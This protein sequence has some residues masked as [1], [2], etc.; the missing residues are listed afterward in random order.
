MDRKAALAS[1]FNRR[2]D[3]ALGRASMASKPKKTVTDDSISKGRREIVIEPSC[4]VNPAFT[5]EDN[6]LRVP[7]FRS[8][9]LREDV[10]KGLEDLKFTKPTVTQ[11]VAIPPILYRE[12]VLCAAQ[13]GTGKTLA[14]LLPIVHHLREEQDR[15]VMS[16]LKRPRALIVLPNR[17]LA[18]QVLKVAKSLCHTARFRSA[19]LTGGKKLRILKSGLESPVDLLVGTPGTLLE[20]RERGRLFFSDVSYLVIDEADSMFDKTFK[21]ETME[22][23]EAINIRQDKPPPRSSLPVD[24]QV[25]IV[26]ATLPRELL[27][28]TLQD[29]LPYLHTC[30]SSLHRVLPHVRHKFVKIAQNEKPEKLLELLR[31]D[32]EIPDRRTVVFCNTTQSCDF[33]GHF[34]TVNEIPHIKLHSSIAIQERSNLFQE[35]Q[36]E[37]ARILLCTDVGSRGL[38]TDVDHVINFD[39]PI[40]TTD[41]I[42]RVG[43]TGRV[44]T[45]TRQEEV[46]V[47]TSLMSHNR[48]VRTALIIE[49]AARTQRSLKSVEA[50]MRQ[51][52]PRSRDIFPSSKGSGRHRSSAQARGYRPVKPG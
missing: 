17:E 7:S 27:V 30:T 6:K 33:L 9:G 34:L 2:R 24:T 40:N 49:E 3:L 1:Q 13:T 38:D 22:L 25:I 5:P 45:R 41:Y 32:L 48:D 35:F 18:F 26:G 50:R 36:K 42:H 31:E 19:L 4:S 39:F 29:M 51:P 16:R 10:L 20:F 43:R 46:A 23:L 11:M 52:I 44:R 14:Y 47:A 37:K 15:G 8:L 12:H 21:S 28:E